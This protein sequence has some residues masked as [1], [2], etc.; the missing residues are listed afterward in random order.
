MKETYILQRNKQKR[1][2]VTGTLFIY[3]LNLGTFLA[4]VTKVAA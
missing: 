3:L 1:V 4:E 2:S